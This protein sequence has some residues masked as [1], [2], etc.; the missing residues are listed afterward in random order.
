VASIPST[1]RVTSRSRTS[2]RTKVV[3]SVLGVGVTLGVGVLSLLDPGVN[4]AHSGGVSMSPLMGI[5]GSLGMDSIF[6][7]SEKI[8]DARWEKIVIVHSGSPSGSAADIADEHRDLGYDGLGFHFVIGNGTRMGDGEIH[9]GY[10]WIDQREGAEL[11]GVRDGFT[12]SGTIEI[13]LVGDGDRR[14]FTQEQLHRLAQVVTTLAERLEIDSEQIHL[15][16]DLA[17][18]TSPGQ[19]FPRA[20]FEQMLSSI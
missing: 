11:A 1:S 5:N 2:M 13:C 14:P 12:S 7:T 10:R 6:Q 8:E 9:V 20:E 18:T 4:A 19:Y 3:W 15:H 16:K 17:G